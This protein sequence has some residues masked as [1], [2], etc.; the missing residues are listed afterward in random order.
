ML[1][2]GVT[3]V[4]LKRHN[5]SECLVKILGDLGAKGEFSESFTTSLSF[6]PVHRVQCAPSESTHST[7][8]KT[9]E[10]TPHPTPFSFIT[11]PPFP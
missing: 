11:T 3:F 10:W 7:P 1:K 6:P 5:F 2:L 8:V 9:D 4:K